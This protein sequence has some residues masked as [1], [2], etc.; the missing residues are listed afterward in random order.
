MHWRGHNYNNNLILFKLRKYEWNIKLTVTA[1]MGKNEEQLPKK[2]VGRLLA[3]S[4]PTVGRQSAN[5]GPTV[6]RESANC[7]PTV[8]YRFYENL[9]PVVGRMLA[10]CR[11]TVG[12][13]SVICRPSVG[14]E[15]LSN[16]RKAS[17][18]REE[19][20]ISTRNETFSLESAILF[21]F[22]LGTN[23]LAI[24]YV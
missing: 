2:T 23:L 21:W 20:C 4:R 13:M 22:F 18:R 9:L 1:V 24:S 5:C 15:P 3:N 12:R 14:W 17:A 19:H 6:G 7:R 11:P 10:V 8:I 16:T